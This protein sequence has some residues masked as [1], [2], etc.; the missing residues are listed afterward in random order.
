M[1]TTQKSLS[2][3]NNFVGGAEV[4]RALKES[5]ICMLINPS[6]YKA[7]VVQNQGLQLP[8]PPFVLI[9]INSDRFPVYLGLA[10]KRELVL[11]HGAGNKNKQKH[12]HTARQSIDPAAVLSPEETLLCKEILAIQVVDDLLD[13]VRVQVC[14][15]EKT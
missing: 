8:R 9:A 1:L 10:L 7:S 6:A 2:D 5:T 4:S 3:G 15:E 12:Y 14:S 11:A 13:F